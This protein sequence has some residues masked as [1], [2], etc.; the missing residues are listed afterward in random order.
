MNNER[1]PGKRP[2]SPDREPASR[3]VQSS[4]L[5]TAT[6]RTDA[7]YASFTVHGV[8]ADMEFARTLERELAAAIKDRD[9][10]WALARRHAKELA[11]LKYPGMTNPVHAKGGV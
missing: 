11:E 6:P 10:G 1:R 9:E 7:Y 8:A 3:E 2:G 5:T 4:P